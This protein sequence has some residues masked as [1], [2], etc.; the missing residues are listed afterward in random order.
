MRMILDAFEL[1][2]VHLN[3][4]TQRELRKS[5]TATFLEQTQPLSL[6]FSAN[7]TVFLAQHSLP[8]FQIKEKQMPLL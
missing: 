6:W 7:N 4:A 2:E 8:N 1:R 5:M 3:A